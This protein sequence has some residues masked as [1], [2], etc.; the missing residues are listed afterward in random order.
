MSDKFQSSSIG[1]HL[2]CSNCGIPLALLPVDQTTI[3]I[4]ISNLD[5]PAE[6]LPMNQTDIESQISWTKSLSE[7]SAK[8]TVESDSNS[9]NIINYQHSDHD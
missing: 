1:Y 7:L 4:T 5:H 8:T 9:I 6:L 3:E 2:F